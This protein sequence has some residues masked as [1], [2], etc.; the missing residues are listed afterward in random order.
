M[1]SKETFLKGRNQFLQ[2]QKCFKKCPNNK[3]SFRKSVKVS[4]GEAL[5]MFE[6]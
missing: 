6:A 2:K 5:F 4:R 1:K 3:S